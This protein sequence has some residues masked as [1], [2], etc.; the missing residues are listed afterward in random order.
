[1][2]TTLPCNRLLGLGCLVFVVS[3]L[4]AQAAAAARSA[5][6]ND[7]PP[8]IERMIERVR[9]QENNP[10]RI[11]LGPDLL[12][13]LQPYHVPDQRKEQEAMNEVFG[14]IRWIVLGI[15]GAAAGWQISQTIWKAPVP[16]TEAPRPRL[17]ELGLGVDGK[18]GVWIREAPP[19]DAASPPRG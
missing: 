14:W 11:D 13:N 3:G 8:P 2:R 19:W 1:M 10:P 17:E 4:A 5:T 7:P 18:D 16:A 15:I 12:K 6:Q 9:A